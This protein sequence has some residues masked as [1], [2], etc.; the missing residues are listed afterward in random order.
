MNIKEYITTKYSTYLESM[1]DDKLN[2]INIKKTSVAALMK[3]M[4][5]DK[6][7]LFD[8]LL[9]HTAIDHIDNNNIEVIYYLYSTSYNR[10]IMLS[11]TLPRTN[12]KIHTVSHV[13]AIAEWLEREVYDFF[14]VLYI[15][16]KDLRRIFLEDDW[17]GFPLRKDYKDYF[18]L[19][20]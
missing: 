2:K 10:N 8:M 14:G 6:S 4:N 11:V 16:H 3:H 18:M 5:A 20:K 15:N 9:D 13:W 12:P 17:I 7:L 1:Q 19:E